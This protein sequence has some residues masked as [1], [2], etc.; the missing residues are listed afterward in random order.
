MNSKQQI[1]FIHESMRGGG[2]EKVFID[3]M[4]RFDFDKY[5][6]S[7]LLLFTGGTHTSAINR[8]VNVISLYNQKRSLGFKLKWHFRSSRNALLKRDIDRRLGHSRFD[9]IISFLEGPALKAH[10]FIT[11][12]ARRN[13]SWVH[14]DLEVNHWTSYLFRNTAE[15]ADIYRKMD[16]V[17]FVSRGALN[18]FVRK[19][20][21]TG[22]F[23]VIPNIIDRDL[24]CRRAS[25]AKHPKTAFTIINVGRLEYQ[26][27]H[28]RLIRVAAELKNRNFDFELWIVG[29][30]PLECKLKALAKKLKVEDRIKFLGYR[31]NPYTYMK[32]A[33]LFLLTSDTEGL[34]TVICESLALGL[35]VVSTR[36]TGS[37]ELLDEGAGILTSTDVNEIAAAVQQL[38]ERPSHLTRIAQKSAER[39]RAFN[40]DNVM[41]R[42]YSLLE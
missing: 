40:P 19:F 20:N 38:A 3:L 41:R 14:V 4:N 8:N 31:T 17:N 11:G 21:V 6:V 16:I 2:A 23:N 18:A 36:I 22:N 1:L 15:E 39:G 27:R 24:I 25:E 37:E 34:P 5:E 13:I 30:G 26:K 33:D 7:L 12:R 35:P 42:I 28:D 29:T 9:T 32:A 10:S